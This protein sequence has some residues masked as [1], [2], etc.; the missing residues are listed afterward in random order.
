MFNYRTFLTVI[1]AGIGMAALPPAFA[2]KNAADP[3]YSG[4]PEGYGA[5]PGQNCT[6]C[7]AF[8][9]GP[10]G[11][12]LLGVPQRYRSGVVYL[13]TVRVT[14]PEQKG[15]GF[16]IS[17]EG[18][19]IHLGDLLLIDA[20]NTRF[21]EGGSAGDYVTHTG[22]GV[23]NSI[24][25]WT[26]N[27]GMYEYDLAWQAPAD[28]EGA[29]T[30]FTAGNAVN[31]G[32]ANNGDRYYADH[33]TIGFANPGDADGDNDVDLFDLAKF[34]TCFNGDDPSPADGCEYLDS[35]DN[36]TVSLDDF[37]DWHLTQTG[38]TALQSAGFILADA[39]RG[40]ALY[41]R[42]WRVI[43][44]QSPSGNHPLYPQAGTQTGSTTYRCKECHG[45]D[46]KGRNGAY[47]LGSPRY[48]GIPG[49]FGTTLTSQQIFDLLKA[50]PAVLPNGHNM[51]AYGMSER[52][53]WDVVK[54][55]LNSVLDTDD[56]IAPDDSFIGDEPSGNILF[57]SVC[58]SCHGGNGTL[59]NFGSIPSPSYIGTVA[60]NDLWLFLHTVRFGHP[61]TPMP[62][63]ELLRWDVQFAADI[64]VYAAT[65]PQ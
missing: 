11:V 39:V 27:G 33:A 63:M 46:Y 14:D 59:I 51:D 53:L 61:G 44:I 21:A 7:H 18:D 29:I 64:G 40:G 8:N 47:G 65:L 6:A 15:A 62:A 25:D 56:Y 16:E 48:T 49:V 43:G 37:A 12:Q 2:S 5:T 52:D 32:Q 17:V 3:G 57:N 45:W 30:F 4:G 34:Q 50:D 42:W 10:G 13:L 22:D 55:T 36:G 38:P 24:A 41:D 35:D 60:N 54:F 23:D 20:I 58:A 1:A 9:E 19:A 31:D 26:A 28:D